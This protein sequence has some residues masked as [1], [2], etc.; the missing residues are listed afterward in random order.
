M[1]FSDFKIGTRLSFAFGLVV[2]LSA[3]SAGLALKELASV[4]SN[5][6]DIVTDNNV[7]IKLNHEM[8]ES[9]HVVSRVMRTMVLLHEKDEVQ[10]E[11]AK[12]VK[13]R[14]RYDH[15]WAALQ[16]FTP[17][18]TGKA[19]RA[20][21]AAAGEIARAL[22]NKV[23]DLAHAGKDDEAIAMLLK[24]AGPATQKWQDVLDE[25]IAFQEANTEK[26][27]AQ[28]VADYNQARSVLIG[29]NALSMA[30]AVLLGWL[31]TRS[32]TAPM[33]RAK[34][35]AGRVAEGDLTVQISG[36]GK[37]ETA[38]LLGALLNMKD[39][40]ARIVGGVRQNAE[41]VATASAQ[42]AQGNNDLSQRTEEQASALEETAAS[43][44]EL[45]ATVKQNADS[46][47]QANQLAMNASTVAVKG[48]EVVAQVVDTMKGINDASKKIV[49]IISVIDGIAFQTNILA[50]NAA[51]EAARA[52]EQG[53]GFAV[54]ASEVR[55]LAGRSAEAAKEI[56]SLISA[57]V[58]RVGQ[59][60]ALVDQAG[61]T[62]T[63][64]VSAIRRVTDLM[65][66]ISAAS[67]EQSA[68]V[69][70]VGEAVVQMDQVTQ[71]NAA[72]VEEMAA[73]A[74]SLKSQAQEL[75]QVVSVFKLETDD[76]H[77]GI[78]LP[79]NAV[80]THKPGAPSLK[81]AAARTRATPPAR[82]PA[83]PTKLLASRPTAQAATTAGG[84]ADWQA[85]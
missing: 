62:M 45:S 18:E 63:E 27:H 53:R 31:I 32:I 54:V 78:A 30:L 23:I 37:D 80:R 67:S 58:E 22:N 52:G 29:T 16:K 20:K 47:R 11:E 44:E 9:V 3:G 48:G 51:V 50:L 24:E 76:G 2:L 39:N 68:G 8:A 10:A 33:N 19:N 57:S 6:D 73:A 28:A 4:E 61:A 12:L 25:N 17:S 83:A 7:K 75:V 43:M 5:L 59:G 82:A 84:N 66:E 13:A 34:D 49:D 36:E 69:S 64:V 72:L 26:Q 46:A 14:A 38:Q 81:S 60:S 74:S 65:G 21:I 56:K 15:G 41:G 85:F 35:A 70:Q 42:I 1:K 71:Q 79:D 55:S 77:L 40:L